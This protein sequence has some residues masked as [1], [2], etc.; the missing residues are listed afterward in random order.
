[1]GNSNDLG[2][3]KPTISFL[4][5]SRS[6]FILLP[7]QSFSEFAPQSLDILDLSL[8]RLLVFGLVSGAMGQR[9]N[10]GDPTL[11]WRED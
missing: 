11:D 9:G 6:L 10:A 4:V 2:Q 1:M 5:Q 7:Q 3:T 8:S